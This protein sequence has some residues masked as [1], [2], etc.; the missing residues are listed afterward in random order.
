MNS[1]FFLTSFQV[2]KGS[3]DPDLVFPSLAEHLSTS[4]L[5]LPNSEETDAVSNDRQQSWWERVSGRRQRNIRGE[6]CPP[7]R[8]RRGGYKSNPPKLQTIEE[9]ESV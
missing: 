9:S 6:E 5:P 8:Q 1:P 7:K 4:D 3:S 2:R